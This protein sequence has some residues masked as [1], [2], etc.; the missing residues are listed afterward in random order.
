MLDYF[1]R[2]IRYTSVS[3]NIGRNAL[4]RS[5]SG[6][7]RLCC[8][9]INKIQWNWLSLKLNQKQKMV[10]LGIIYKKGQS[11]WVS[12]L[13]A[14]ID[15]AESRLK[16]KRARA[17]LLL[18]LRSRKSA[19]FSLLVATSLRQRPGIRTTWM[20]KIII[21][22]RQRVNKRRTAVRRSPSSLR[23]EMKVSTFLQW[24][25]TEAFS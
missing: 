13:V 9:K 23:W 21:R 17:V 12:L 3:Q 1:C 8:L 18:W 11:A 14:S 7:S 19:M 16:E 25:V 10:L 22:Q 5:L 24:N 15:A 20:S 2:C 4:R 6:F